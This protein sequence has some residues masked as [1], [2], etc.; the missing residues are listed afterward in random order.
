M[1]I[2]LLSGGA[3]PYKHRR[4][5][6]MLLKIQKET[7]KHSWQVKCRQPIKRECSSQLALLLL[8]SLTSVL[9]LTWFL[10]WSSSLGKKNILS[11][12]VLLQLRLKPHFAG[13]ESH[14]PRHSI[15]GGS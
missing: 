1:P 5:D 7:R 10:A 13:S 11:R 9:E 6:N 15:V 8:R 3:I 14:F 12:S 2:E 4:D